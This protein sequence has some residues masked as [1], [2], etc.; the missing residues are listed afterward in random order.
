MLVVRGTKKLRDRLKG[1]PAAD[2]DVSTTSL[3]DWFATALFWRPQVALLVNQRTLLPVFVELAPAATLLDRVPG[4]I[5]TVLRRHGVDKAFLVAEQ[6]AMSEVRIAPTNDRSVVGVMNEF[7]FHA[8]YLWKEGPRDLQAL[9]L[10]MSSLILGPL[11]DRSG[12]PDRELA[13]V[14]GATEPLATVIAFPGQPASADPAPR[15]R[16]T[17]GNVYQLKVSL[18]DTKPPIWRRVLVDGTSTL[19][20]VHE[21]IQAA[22]GWWNYHLHEFELGPK[23]YGIPDPDQDW[24]EPPQDERRTR[25]D[26]IAGEGSSFRYTYDFGDGWDHR[27]VVE[28]VLPR[29]ADT[30]TPVCIDGRRACPP[31]DCGGTWGYRELLEILADSAHPEHD[32]RQEWLGRP[33]DPEAFDPR[34][35]EDNLRNGRRALFDN[36]E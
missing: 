8:E 14:V 34:E 18:L 12:S 11:H 1:A 24:G 33:F 26:A 4:A 10:R 17:S 36:D 32:E 29:T 22:F 35:F 20:H 25:L 23:R 30:A 21:V 6:D 27:V 16:A 19:D 7:A 5:E 31:E 2:R 9:S 15:T 3:G 13:A 28:K